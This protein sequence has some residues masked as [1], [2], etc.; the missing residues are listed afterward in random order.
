MSKEVKRFISRLHVYGT[1]EDKFFTDWED[2][3]D[4]HTGEVVYTQHSIMCGHLLEELNNPEE[5]GI[6][7]VNQYIKKVIK[8]EKGDN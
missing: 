4:T 1:G 3:I 6:E 5:Y 2:I 8:M 7:D